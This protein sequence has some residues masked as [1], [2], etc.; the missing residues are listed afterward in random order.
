MVASTPP[1]EPHHQAEMGESGIV[2]WIRPATQAP[3][4]E[5][6]VR[7]GCRSKILTR[8]SAR[9]LPVL[10]GGAASGPGR[11]KRER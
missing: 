2:A 6:I 9:R 3:C 1:V 4:P 11:P 7:P 8:D 10:S 5:R